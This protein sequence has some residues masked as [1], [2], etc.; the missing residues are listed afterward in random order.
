MSS[1]GINIGAFKKTS[2]STYTINIGAIPGK[3]GIIL[4]TGTCNGQSSGDIGTL[5]KSFNISGTCNGQSSGNIGVLGTGVFIYGYCVGQSRSTGFITFAKKLSGTC[6]VRSYSYSAE[7]IFKSNSF[8]TNETDYRISLE[9]DPDNLGIL[10]TRTNMQALTNENYWYDLRTQGFYP[11]QYHKDCTTYS[12]LYYPHKLKQHRGLITGGLDGYI[13][14]FDNKVTSDESLNMAEP[15]ESYFLSPAIQLN[16]EDVNGK[17]SYLIFNLAGQALGSES[18]QSDGI[19]YELYVADTPEQC[20][21][22]IKDGVSPTSSGTITGA[23][24]STRQ[25]VMGRGAYA[26]IKIYNNNISETWSIN[27]ISGAIKA[28][29]RV[30]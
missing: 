11:E 2:G 5:Q 28:A 6:V 9:Y 26:V 13:H 25:R 18:V 29:G 27:N 17:L 10:I 22:N 12:S 7:T 14:I 16:E 1:Y 4:L 8:L 19:S 24:R 20:Y 15:I 21:E 3:I 30:G 23:G